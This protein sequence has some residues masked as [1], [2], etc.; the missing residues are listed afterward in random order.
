MRKSSRDGHAEEKLVNRGRDTPCFCPTLQLLDMSTLCG[1]MSTEGETLQVSVLTYRCSIY[2]PFVGACKQRRDTPSFCPTLQVLYMSTFVGACQQRER[3][4]EFLSYLT[5]ARYV[6]PLWEHVNKGRDTPSS[7]PTLQ[8][9]DMSTL[10]GS[11]S[12]EERHSKFLSYLT[13]ARY[14]HPLWEHVNRGRDTPS[15]CPTLQL[16]DM[17]TLCGS[18]STEGQTFQISVLPYRCSICPPF[19]SVLVVAQ[20]S[21]EVPERLTNYPVFFWATFLSNTHITLPNAV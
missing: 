4:S 16:L 17:S 12:T 14:V 6:H 3:H 5:V 18:M 1:S 10:C 11:M 7:C 20:P 13:S 19:V 21:S 9:L 15:F 2:P 8:V